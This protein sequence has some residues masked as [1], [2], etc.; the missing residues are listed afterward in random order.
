MGKVVTIPSQKSLN[1]EGSRSLPLQVH[2]RA[3]GHH[4]ASLGYR[5]WAQLYLYALGRRSPIAYL[6]MDT[7][8]VSSVLY[9]R[10]LYDSATT[11]LGT[12]ECGVA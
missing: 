11:D 4:T 12:Y 10:R 9:T 2:G 1:R 3:E 8:V 7:D 5:E 6:Y